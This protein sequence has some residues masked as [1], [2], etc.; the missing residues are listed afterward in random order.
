MI[1]EQKKKNCKKLHNIKIYK[2]KSRP[3]QKKTKVIPMM[4]GV[5]GAFPKHLED[6][7]IA[8]GLQNLPFTN[9]R[10]QHYWEER[11]FCDDIYD[12]KID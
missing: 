12:I 5:L 9:Y 3:W 10:N 4:I 6:Y 7:L 1:V 2:Y 8:S 11:T